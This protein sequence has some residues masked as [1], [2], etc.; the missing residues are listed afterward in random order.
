MEGVYS[1]FYYWNRT[2]RELRQ[3]G[4]KWKAPDDWV[5]IENAHPAIITVDEWQELKA[6]MEPIV[7]GNRNKHKNTIRARSSH[8][9]LTGENIAGEPMFICTDCGGGMIGNQTVREYYYYICSTYKNKGSAGCD[10]NVFIRKEDLESQ[11]FKLIKK[12]FSPDRVKEIAS[13]C[14][15]ILADN[16]RDQQKAEKHIKNSI[17]NINRSLNNIM[18]AIEQ[19][20]TSSAVTLLVQKLEKLQEEQAVLESELSEIK[21]DQLRLPR[22]NKN[23]VLDRVKLLEQIMKDP[24]IRNE[25]KRLAVRYFVRQMRFDPDKR[26]VSVYFGQTLPMIQLRSA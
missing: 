21:K 9:L 24:D 25:E 4:Q 5:I 12:R 10:K 18:A 8:Y 14:S 20:G 11:L 16:S 26:E 6:V 2:G 22:F 7:Q 3:T 1:G 23:L 17:D 19:S 13:E 15:E